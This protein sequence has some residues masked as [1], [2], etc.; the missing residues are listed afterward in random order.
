MPRKKQVDPMTAEKIDR[1]A[2]IFPAR[3]DKLV[4]SL[5]VLCNCNNKSSY[6]WTPDI[7]KRAWVEIAKGLQRAAESFDLDLVIT[8]DDVNIA[9]IDTTKKLK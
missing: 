6:E 4:K 7:V 3:V 1:F 8:L 9:D 5:D 2:R